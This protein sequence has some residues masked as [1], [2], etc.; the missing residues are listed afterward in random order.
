[1]KIMKVIMKMYER[2]NVIFEE[3]MKWKWYNEM[4]KEIMK[5]NNLNIVM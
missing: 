5:R 2:E 3:I 4:K 1:M